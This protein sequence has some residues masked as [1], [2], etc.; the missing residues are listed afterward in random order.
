ML[1]RGSFVQGD[2]VTLVALDLVLGNTPA[3]VMDITFIRYVFYVHLHYPAADVAGF[4]IPADMI[5]DFE[6]LFAHL[7]LTRAI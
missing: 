4:G 3:R 7:V 6:W 1:Q 5:A 2:V